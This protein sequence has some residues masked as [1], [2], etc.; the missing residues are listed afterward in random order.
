M[1]D[2]LIREISQRFG[3]GDKAEGLITSLVGLIFDPNS[4]GIAGL[5]TR[6][7]EQG[8]GDLFS[9]WLGGSAGLPTTINSQQL[10]SVLGSAQV[11]AIA[12]KLGI[13]RGT[14]TAA[15][16]AALPK[17]IGVLTPNGQLPTSVPTAVTSMLGGLGGLGTAGAGV[18]DA[19]HAATSTTALAIED[20]AG[21]GRGWLKWLVLAA[22]ILALGY[23]VLNRQPAPAPAPPAASS[24]AAAPTTTPAA[25]AETPAQAAVADA[26]S[27][28]SALVPGKFS[29]DDLV[30]ALNLMAVHFDTGS[31][32][33]SADSMDVLAAAANALKAAPA[34]SKVEIGGY[35]D[36]T[37]DPAAN[38]KLSDERANAVRSKLI[39]L[40][41][42]ADSLVAK[43]YGDAKPVADNATEEGR[44]K[45]RRM[46]FTVLP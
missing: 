6:F 10:E 18:A 20:A 45:N 16:A 40:G 9:S 37:G 15:A 3:L 44:A 43:G 5:L 25:S 34:G 17:I 42:A 11:G 24:P 31:A 4:G 38:L 29:A 39:E 30:K 19:A 12:D 26:K 1:F 2:A 46:E 8:L 21:G 7:R 35:T 14:V 36:N 41:V 23:C 27:V 13:A 28:L 22:I 32:T 33:I